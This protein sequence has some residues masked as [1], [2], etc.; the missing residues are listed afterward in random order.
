[1]LQEVFEK[2]FE[3]FSTAASS[4]SFPRAGIQRTRVLTI[5]QSKNGAR[6]FLNFFSKD[7]RSPGAGKKGC[8][9]PVQDGL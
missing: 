7:F 6:D 3:I 2:T 9:S 8:S 1:M 5:A 4:S